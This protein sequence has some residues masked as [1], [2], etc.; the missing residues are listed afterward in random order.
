MFPV[1]KASLKKIWPSYVNMHRSL[2]IIG[3]SKRFVFFFII[4]LN[5]KKV[6]EMLLNMY[7]KRIISFLEL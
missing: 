2:Q 7:V 4:E 3:W 5:V 6:H 1:S